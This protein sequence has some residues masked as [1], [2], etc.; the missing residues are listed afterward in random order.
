V[1]LTAAVVPAFAQGLAVAHQHAAHGRVRHRVGDRARRQLDGAR[2]VRDVAV[3]GPT[4]T[5]FQNAT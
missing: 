4:S 2:E 3:Y 5:P 1:R